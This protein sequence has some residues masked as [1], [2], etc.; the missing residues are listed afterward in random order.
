MKE[1]YYLTTAIAYASRKPHIGNT[2]EIIFADAIARFKRMQNFD[3]RFVTGT[4]EHGQKV[5]ELAKE[6]GISAQNY[7]D[8]VSG[9]IKTIWD[10]MGSTYDTFIRTTDDYHEKVVQKIFKKL[11]DQGDIYKSEYE[12]L[13]CIPC[14]SFFTET[15]LVDGK[16]PDCGREVV[17]TK[18]EAY[19]FKMSKYQD[20]SLIHIYLK[21]PEHQIFALIGPSGCGKSTLLKSLN[22]MNDLIPECRITGKILLDGTD[23]YKDLDVNLL[24]KMCIRDSLLAIPCCRSK[25][26]AAQ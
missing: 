12:G 2:Y 17:P 11:Y 26:A 21:V 25:T 14:E 3:V 7:V 4:D 24:R 1:K 20:L 13:Y 15:Q 23:V 22:R 8:K 5:E 9:E 10:L 18:E 16:C 19:F 6:A